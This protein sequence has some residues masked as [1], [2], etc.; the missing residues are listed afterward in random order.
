MTRPVAIVVSAV[1]VVLLFV[2]LVAVVASSSLRSVLLGDALAAFA[3]VLAIP[4]MH[5]WVERASR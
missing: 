3:C 2:A 4:L 5:Y 1:D